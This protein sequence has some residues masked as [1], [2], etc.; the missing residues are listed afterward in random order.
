MD[1]EF[2][3]ICGEFSSNQQSIDIPTRLKTIR[4]TSFSTVG[5]VLLDHYYR[6]AYLQQQGSRQEKGIASLLISFLCS[7][8]SMALLLVGK[9]HASYKETMVYSLTHFWIPQSRP[10]D[11]GGPF[12]PFTSHPTAATEGMKSHYSY[13]SPPNNVQPPRRAQHLIIKTLALH[14]LAHSTLSS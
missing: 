3:A 8:F 7:T 6:S 11:D 13:A 4:S 9:V 14:Q 2:T 10:S 12:A 1:F 5:V